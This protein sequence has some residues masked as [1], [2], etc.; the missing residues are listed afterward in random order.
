MLKA[1]QVKDTL[2][3]TP[4]FKGCAD[5]TLADIAMIATE[6]NYEK[7]D[8]IYQ[9]GEDSIN[10]YV[11]VNGIVTFLNKSS[12]QFINNLTPI[13]RVFEHSMIF[14]WAAL[15]PEYPHRL[16]SAQCLED[17][18]I[19]SINGAKLLAILERDTQ[20]GFLVMKRLCSLIANTFVEKP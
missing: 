6:V 14:G 5:Q 15:V 8:I 12:L 4:L 20:S 3:H 7:G 10:V 13:Q 16:G 1:E 17:S 9:T 11:L 2:C 19:L 18:K